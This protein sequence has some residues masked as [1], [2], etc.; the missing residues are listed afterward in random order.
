MEDDLKLKKMEDNLKYKKKWKMTS[1]KTEDDLK[2]IK[3]KITS[4][5]MKMEDDLN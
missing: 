3:W 2:K 4:K 5:N 1:K